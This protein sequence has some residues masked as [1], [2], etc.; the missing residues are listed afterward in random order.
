MGQELFE[1]PDVKGWRGGRSW[2]NSSRLLTRY[3]AITEL[4]RNVQRG[5]Q[6]EGIDVVALLQGTEC[7]TS[8]DVVDY[9]TKACLARPLEASKRQELVSNLE[10]L[11]PIS[12]WASQRDTVNR[13]LQDLLVLLVSVPEYQFQ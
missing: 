12:Q 6:R 3:N 8:S 5:G 1:P 9:L 4:V 11:P 2:V 7:Q 13:R 10:D